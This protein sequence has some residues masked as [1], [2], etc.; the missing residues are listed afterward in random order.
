MCGTVLAG[1]TAPVDERKLVD[2]LRRGEADAFEALVRSHHASLLRLA[3]AYAP[4]V[5]VAE[6]VVQDT[7]LA[8]VRAIGRFEGRS[9]LRTWLFGILVRRARSGAAREARHDPPAAPDGLPAARFRPSDDPVAPG[10]WAPGLAPRAWAESPEQLL[11]RDE[12]RRLL[13]DAIAAL[14]E[15]QRAV[16]TL[17]DVEGL[18][19]E[20][21]RNVLGLSETNQRVLLH[22]AR[23][24]VRAALEGYLDPDL[25]PGAGA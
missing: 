1:A 19:A 4:T 5:A 3:R 23:T 21:A 18:S 16:I 22:R 13:T 17:R 11:L 6:E 9:S 10:H 24:R 15:R 14:P 25:R 8:A 7:W 2:A 20:E 12:L